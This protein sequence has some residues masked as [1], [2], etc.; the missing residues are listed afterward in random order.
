LVLI[1]LLIPFP[2]LVSAV[3]PLPNTNS[4]E[5]LCFSP[6]GC[7]SHAPFALPSLQRHDPGFRSRT[8]A[9]TSQTGWSPLKRPSRLGYPTHPPGWSPRVRE[10]IKEHSTACFQSSRVNSVRAISK[11][12]R[13]EGEGGGMIS[14]LLAE[15]QGGGAMKIYLGG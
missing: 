12:A 11:A 14:L 1:Q 2:M 15:T 9:G 8:L 7:L 3:Q 6:T 13:R 10:R 4:N 5:S